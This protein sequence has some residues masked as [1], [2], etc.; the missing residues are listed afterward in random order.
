[1][2]RVIEGVNALLLIYAALCCVSITISV[3]A[4]TGFLFHVGSTSVI[5][6]MRLHCRVLRQKSEKPPI[7]AIRSQSFN[8][9]VLPLATSPY[10]SL[11]PLKSDL[12]V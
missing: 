10:Q 7:K 1:M 8:E 3:E 4:Y 6:R 12:L 5:L 11:Q 9:S 2:S